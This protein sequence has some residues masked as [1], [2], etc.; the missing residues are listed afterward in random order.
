MWETGAWTAKGS[1]E[2]GAWDEEAVA[3]GERPIALVPK[4]SWGNEA[5]NDRGSRGTG[6]WDAKGSREAGARAPHLRV[7]EEDDKE[8]V[9]KEED[10]AEEDEEAE[11]E[12]EEDP[13]EALRDVHCCHDF[14]ALL[15]FTEEGNVFSLQALDVPAAKTVKTKAT[16]IKEFMPDIGDEHIT[17]IVTVPQKAL[18]D[19]SDEFVVLVSAGG[20]AKKVAVS[21][22]R[23]LETS[24]KRGQ[25][26]V[27]F[28]LSEGDKLK[29]ALRG[30]ENSALVMVS[31]KGFVLRTSLGPDWKIMG[32]K[33]VGKK[34]M[35]CKNQA[36]D[37]A[38]CCV[39]EMTAQELQAVKE[40]KA[41]ALAK[42]EERK[43]ARAKAEAEAGE[44]GAT[45]A[46]T[47]IQKANKAKAGGADDDDSENGGD[48]AQDAQDNDSD[49][50]DSDGDRPDADMKDAD[51][52]GKATSQ[53]PGDSQAGG[54]S[55]TPADGDG[56][57]EEVQPTTTEKSDWGTCLLMVTENGWGM[58][59]PFTHKRLQIMN[60]GRAGIR[61]MR[62]GDGDDMIGAC[63]VGGKVEPKKPADPRKPFAI[64][65]ADNK[66]AIEKEC[67][68]MGEEKRAEVHAE[69]KAWEAKEEAQE[70]DAEDKAA[71]SGTISAYHLAMVVAKKR[72]SELPQSEVQLL[73][74]R[75]EAEREQNEK[76]ME[77]YRCALAARSDSEQVMVASCHGFISRV[78]VDSVPVIDKKGLC[79]KGIRIVKIKGRDFLSSVS[80]LSAVDDAPDE[81]EADGP[82]A[83][84][85]AEAS[86]MEVEAEEAAEEDEPMA[87]PEKK[88]TPR[89]NRVRSAS[90]ALPNTP[91][92]N[93]KASHS[94]GLAAASL[95]DTPME[96][97]GRR[98]R[99]KRP[100]SEVMSP[101][102]DDRSVARPSLARSSAAATQS[103]AGR[104]RG[105]GA[106]SPKAGLRKALG[107][108]VSGTLRLTQPA[109][110]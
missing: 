98:I 104:G 4:E 88:T 40:A 33:A 31:E 70:G 80:A 5:W 48:D 99:G 41:K 3:W 66:M 90:L 56:A 64:F 46:G 39:S 69:L 105:R 7:K 51:D 35:K 36:G 30:G 18:R 62:V 102:V 45:E 43:E 83:A 20:L 107:K 96:S 94:D 58:R 78:M 59:V 37:L 8:E 74:K 6:A 103:G 92:T 9:K 110:D 34:A 86:A 106:A 10:E 49:G 16:P 81:A 108:R 21:S 28:R 11:A 109:F 38:A 63:V 52:A 65:Y 32:P 85:A 29:W 13:K 54:A 75:T 12:K 97:P 82:V 2:N 24:R 27:C 50:G 101:S 60:R 14:D 26:V 84:P 55:A 22:F 79:G 87:E 76:L 93:R 25:G 73:E 71:N 100:A 23:Q 95:L 57:E 15:V 1:W 17:A 61:L 67:M 44:E 47:G 91:P 53:A 68:D 42:A 77:E 19:Q 89:K 72:F